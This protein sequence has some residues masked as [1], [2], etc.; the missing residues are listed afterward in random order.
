MFIGS[1]DEI[2]LQDNELTKL[3]FKIPM[4]IDLSRKLQ[5]YDLLDDIYYDVDK[6]VDRL[7]K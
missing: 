3:G 5:F 7:W 2:I 1:F 6:V 4:M